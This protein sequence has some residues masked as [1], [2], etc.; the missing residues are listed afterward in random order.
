MISQAETTILHHVICLVYMQKV[1]ECERNKQTKTIA[2]N[3]RFIFNFFF[4]EKTNI[5]S[6]NSNIM[7]IYRNTRI[8]W[9]ELMRISLILILMPDKKEKYIQTHFV[10]HFATCKFMA[11][12][13]SFFSWKLQLH[14]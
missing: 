10:N 13:S 5:N 9:V 2:E 4:L 11:F 1:Q 12:L 8:T 14:T 3:G 7:N 6:I